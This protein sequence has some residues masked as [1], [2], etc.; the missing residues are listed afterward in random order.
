MNDYFTE[1]TDDGIWLSEAGRR[2][3]FAI[4]RDKR[5]RYR[6]NQ[7]D[8][9]MR[10]GVGLF[11]IIGSLPHSTL[12]HNFVASIGNIERFVEKNSRPFIAKVY[13]PPSG[14]KRRA[15]AC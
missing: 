3:W 7:R 11:L 10:A 5:I 6:P 14:A 12:A 13:Q 4:S 15:G 2:G 9:A 8:A 1:Q